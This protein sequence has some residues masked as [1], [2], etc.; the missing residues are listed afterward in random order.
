MRGHQPALHALEEELRTQRQQRGRYR[1]LKDQPRVVQRKSGDDG[2]A[3]STRTDEGRQRCR[4]DADH[5]RD[6]HARQHVRQRQRDV[7]MAQLFQFAEPH[8]L[9]DAPQ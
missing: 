2:F 7:D 5:G 9:G 6:P 4:A 3:Q 1:A 8:G